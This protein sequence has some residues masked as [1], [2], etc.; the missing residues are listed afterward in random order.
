[1]KTESLSPQKSSTKPL[2]QVTHGFLSEHNLCWLIN[3]QQKLSRC[4]L[5]NH[6]RKTFQ[7]W[8][9]D[10]WA[11]AAPVDSEKVKENWLGANLEIIIETTSKGDA[12]IRQHTH[13]CW[14][15]NS[16]W[17]LSHCRLKNHQR[18]CFHRWPMDSSA[19]TTPVDSELMNEN[20][21][22]T[23]SEIINKTISSGDAWIHQRPQ[24]LLTQN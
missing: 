5:R 15:K 19:P 7:R 8:H 24:P 21:G 16:Q 6:H 17:K 2:P 12:W 10:S 11:P 20:S 14:F 3:S 9:M 13:P 23:D 22:T 4:R 1:M 18:N